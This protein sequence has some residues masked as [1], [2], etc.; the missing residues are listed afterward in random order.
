LYRRKKR[1]KINKQ[2]V[3]IQIQDSNEEYGKFCKDVKE[4]RSEYK[5]KIYKLV[6]KIGRTSVERNEVLEERRS[7]FQELAKENTI[8]MEEDS[9]ISDGRDE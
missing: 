8:V 5:S 6:V 3:D 2:I 4:V 7:Y 1:K 9:I